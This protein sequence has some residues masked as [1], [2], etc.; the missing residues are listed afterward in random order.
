MAIDFTKYGKVVAPPSSGTIDFSKYGTA[1]AAPQPQVQPEQKNSFVGNLVKA[2][3]TTLARPFQAGAELLGASAEDVNTVS[4]KLSGGLVAPVPQ[5]AAD[6]KKDIGRAGQTVA[7]GLNPV[8]GGALFGAGNSLEQG[9]DLLSVQTAFQAALGAG[10]GKVID[11]V[12]KPLF[13]AAGKV[14]GS[15][16]PQI[17]KDVAG[18]GAGA[19]AEFAA[20]HKMPGVVSKIAGGIESGAN[21][22][23]STVNKPFDLAATA[24][25]NMTKKSEQQIEESILSKY[26]KGVKPSLGTKTTPTKLQN[27]RDDVVNAVKTIKDN[28]SNLKFNDA[29][30]VEIVGE[31]PKSLQQLA[32]SVEQTKK[33]VFTK[34]DTLAKQAGEA[35]IQVQTKPIAQELDT[36]INNK[37]LQLTNPNAVKYA[38]LTQARYAKAGPLDATTAQDV[39]Q[40]YNKSLEAFYR[41]PSYDNATQAAIDAM[42]ANNMRKSLD[43]GITG[44]TGEQYSALKKQYGALKS[45]EKDVIKAALRDARSNTKGLI[46]FTDIFSG[47]QVVNGILS[48]NPAQVGAGLAQKGIATF[49]KYLNNPNRAIEKLFSAAEELPQATLSKSFQTIKAPSPKAKPNNIT[50]PKTVQPPKAKSKLPSKPAK[51]KVDKSLYPKKYDPQKGSATW[52]QKMR[53]ANRKLDEEL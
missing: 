52:R 24:V 23:E 51:P 21:K 50:I 6:V 4:N 43:E 19:I 2:P 39:I 15:I 34:Y 10:G 27:Y 36:V 46:D 11:M 31:T 25:K 53:D 1:V 48:L 14:V 5:N 7:L 35:G 49:Y 42:V 41:N 9:N 12:G 32:D 26:E 28:K 45:I 3:L 37:A 44:L 16:T 17:L 18:K 22:L 13:D 47:G 33:S 8:A 40:N 20:Q 38:K 30:G 29:D